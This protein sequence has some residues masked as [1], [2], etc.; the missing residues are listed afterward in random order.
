MGFGRVKVEEV[1]KELQAQID[2]AIEFGLTLD[3]LDG[4]RH[5]HLFPT[6]FP[7]V[8]ELALH[9][10]IKAVRVLRRVWRDPDYGSLRRLFFRTPLLSSLYLLNRGTFNKN[11][12]VTSDYTYGAVNIGHAKMEELRRVVVSSANFG[13]IELIVHP[14]AEGLRAIVEEDFMRVLKNRGIELCRFSDI[15]DGKDIIHS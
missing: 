3:H 14:N 6:I 8:C 7:A 12:L 1:K 4:H 5:A 15:C 11:G 10:K 13:V 2:K 9:Y